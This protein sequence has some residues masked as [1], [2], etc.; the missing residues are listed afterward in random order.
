MVWSLLCV[1]V[2]ILAGGYGWS[3]FTLIGRVIFLGFFVIWL[4]LM[5]K[6]FNRERYM[7][8]FLGELAARQAG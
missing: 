7:I 6:A 2:G 4:F 1:P 8:P 5:Y 3:A